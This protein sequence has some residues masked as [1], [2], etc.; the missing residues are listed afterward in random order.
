MF[1]LE[2]G[3]PTHNNQNQVHGEWHFLFQLCHW[4]IHSHANLVV[5]SED[6][7][8]FIDQAFSSLTLGEI[9]QAMLDDCND[10]QLSF[11]SG[12]ILNTFSTSASQ[13]ADWTQWLFFT[14]GNIAWK[15]A[16]FGLPT[17]G[18]IHEA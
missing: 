8:D 14:P 13:K 15:K 5:G 17:S 7:Q 9:T 16:T 1:F 3:E 18:D 10:L 2:I 4:H 12:S 6:E 11:N